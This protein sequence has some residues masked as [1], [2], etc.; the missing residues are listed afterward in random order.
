MTRSPKEFG[1]VRGR[2]WL[3]VAVRRFLLYDVFLHEL[4]HLQVVDE[5]ARDTMRKY[6]G[7][8]RAQEFADYW[9]HVLW[10]K[11]F[12]HPSLEHH[13]PTKLEIETAL[14]GLPF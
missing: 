2:Q 5:D 3:P 9:R 10:S 11:P 1:A 12:E 13:P 4:G 7:E 8:R 6:A 14:S